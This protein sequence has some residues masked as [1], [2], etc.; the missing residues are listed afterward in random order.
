[1]LAARCV[2]GDSVIGSVVSP[3]PTSFHRFCRE[4][5]STIQAGQRICHRHPRPRSEHKALR[6]FVGIIVVR[7]ARL[8]KAVSTTHTPGDCVV[9]RAK[10]YHIVS[11]FPLMVSGPA[12]TMTM[13][14]LRHARD[15]DHSA[16][17]GRATITADLGLPSF[18]SPS[19]G[20]GNGGDGYSMSP[21]PLSRCPCCRRSGLPSRRR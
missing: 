4:D 1:M 14:C 10:S 19:V 18:D 5:R 17:Q 9:T 16:P 20:V 21:T 13:S 15:G 6:F 8:R 7:G 12:S 3:A 11:S 2:V